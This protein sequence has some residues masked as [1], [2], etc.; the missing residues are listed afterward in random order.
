MNNYG[1]PLTN[2]NALLASTLHFTVTLLGQAD[3]CFLP[4]PIVANVNTGGLSCSLQPVKLT[5]AG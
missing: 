4:L 2:D 3:F 1:M 5:L